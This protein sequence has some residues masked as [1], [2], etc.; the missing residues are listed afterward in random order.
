[1][2]FRLLGSDDGITLTEL[3][4]RSIG[5]KKIKRNAW[6]GP[7]RP[8]VPNGQDARCPSELVARM[9]ED[10]LRLAPGKRRTHKFKVAVGK[11]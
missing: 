7:Y 1:M 10:W 2:A 8:L 4:A 3:D 11:K 9:F 5:A 6:T